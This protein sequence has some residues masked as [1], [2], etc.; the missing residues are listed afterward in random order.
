MSIASKILFLSVLLAHLAPVL[1]LLLV[2]VATA[3]PVVL[4]S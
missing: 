3:L 4:A 2:V 1:L